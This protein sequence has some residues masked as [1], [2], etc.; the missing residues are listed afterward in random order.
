MW[1]LHLPLYQL[2]NILKLF[3]IFIFS[4]SIFVCYLSKDEASWML[5]HAVGSVHTPGDQKKAN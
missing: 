4:T 3:L 5:G 1:N 2:E